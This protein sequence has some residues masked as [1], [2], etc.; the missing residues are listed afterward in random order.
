MSQSLKIN[1]LLALTVLCVVVAPHRLFA[2]DIHFVIPTD[3]HD[4]GAGTVVD[5]Y[6]DPGKSVLNVVEGT[7][8]FES[9]T[10]SPVSVAVSTDASILTIW[11]VEPVFN[12]GDNSIRFTG[13]VPKGFSEEGLL[14]EIK[15]SSDVADTIGISMVDANGYLN[16]GKGTLVPIRTYPIVAYTVPTVVAPENNTIEKTRSEPPIRSLSVIAFIIIIGLACI[17]GYIK[18]KK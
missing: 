13:G 1:F 3:R 11:P 4:D 18:H 7:I 12:K 10:H 8:R 17:Y 6:I 9:A 15:I 2:A 5:V 14:F 16:D